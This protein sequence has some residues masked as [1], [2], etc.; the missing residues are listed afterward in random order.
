MTVEKMTVDMCEINGAWYAEDKEGETRQVKTCRVSDFG[1]N[2][3]WEG[4]PEDMPEYRIPVV[5][6]AT[7]FYP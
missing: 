3:L 7:E 5:I 6:V 1:N 4:R 2:V